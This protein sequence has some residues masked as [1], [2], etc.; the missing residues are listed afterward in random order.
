VELG[1]LQGAKQE[2]L[3]LEAGP[4]DFWLD[5]FGSGWSSVFCWV[6][7]LQHWRLGLSFY[8][9]VFFSGMFEAIYYDRWILWTLS[10]SVALKL[11][12]R[13]SASDTYY[14]VSWVAKLLCRFASLYQSRR[15]CGGVSLD[16]ISALGTWLG[17]WSASSAILDLKARTL[18]A[19]TLDSR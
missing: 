19:T 18:G 14:G 11:D 5:P 13:G 10:E 15:G 8:L 7:C 12:S 3:T 6:W 16:A 2:V 1:W 4:G 17:A 9:E